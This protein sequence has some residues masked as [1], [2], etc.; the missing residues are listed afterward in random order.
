VRLAQGVGWGDERGLSLGVSASSKICSSWIELLVK[1]S[2]LELTH[3]G[4]NA[5]YLRCISFLY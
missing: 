5:C 1:A 2:L 3:G 4:L